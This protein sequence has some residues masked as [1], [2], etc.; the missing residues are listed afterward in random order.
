MSEFSLID[1]I[2]GTLTHDT[3]RYA[4]GAGGTFL[5]VNTMLARRLQDRKIRDRTPG[6]SQI[7][8]EV[9]TS[10]RTVLIFAATGILIGLGHSSG[11]VP[12]YDKVSDFGWTYLIAS[13]ALIIVAHD[14]WFY[15][16]H[17]LLHTRRFFRLA[18]RTHHQS[19]NP[20]P[21]TSYSFDI[22][23]A[24]LNALFLPIFVALVPM[25]TVALLVF[26]FHMMLRNALG[27][28][29][30]E[31]FPAD[32]NGKPLL[33][34][35]TSVTH[36]DLHHSHGR[37]NMG[38]YFTW[39]DRLMGTEHPDYHKEFARVARR[40]GFQSAGWLRIVTVSGLLFLAGKE[41]RAELS[42]LYSAPYLGAVVRFEPCPGDPA[43]TC[44][45]ALW[46]WETASWRHMRLGEFMI[47]GLR[48]GANGWGQGR[49]LHP[50]TG[51]SFRGSATKLPDGR[52]RL[53][54]CA[55][56][57]CATQNWVPLDHLRNTL[58]DLD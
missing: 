44:G 6:W 3:L 36:H 49:L 28:C 2:V 32:R 34:W 23:E 48:P 1:A 52:L 4:L 45:R 39:W 47:T 21:F 10:A 17:R 27:H 46:G 55:G 24:V 56:P 8:R 42:G 9:L 58:S 33:D 13:L 50:E 57:I 12:I 7:K 53:K 14:G 31:V 37:Y 18:H 30:Y 22:T 41:A 38:L 19:H 54:G 16:T 51:L 29:G 26:L 20:T 25:N 40:V 35:M 11:L 15:W 5:V 43:S